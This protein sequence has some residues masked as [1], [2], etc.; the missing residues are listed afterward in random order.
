MRGTRTPISLYSSSSFPLRR[1]WDSMTAMA[2][3]QPLP[4]A[5]QP[6]QSPEKLPPGF[7]AVS[8]RD[9]ALVTDGKYRCA[10]RGSG[11]PRCRAEHEAGRDGPR[12]G[13]HS[14]DWLAGREPYRSRRDASQF[15]TC[16]FL[17][18]QSTSLD[19]TIRPGR[20][21]PHQ[22]PSLPVPGFSSGPASL[23]GTPRD[24]QRVGWAPKQ[25]RRRRWPR[26]WLAP[27]P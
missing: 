13:L 14:I 19:G 5:A 6:V 21:G 7:Y 4:W 8:V 24:S 25:R 15:P 18:P 26:S 9:G 20:A 1:C 2:T 11:P 23:R 12:A 17:S 22:Q 27:D 3:V 16:T 10:G